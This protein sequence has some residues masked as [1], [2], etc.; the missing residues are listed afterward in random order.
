MLSSCLA[1]GTGRR[2]KPGV[3][4]PAVLALAGACLASCQAIDGFNRDPEVIFATGF[5]NSAIEPR[6]S[7][8][9]VLVDLTPPAPPA[10]SWDALETGPYINGAWINYEA[11]DDSQRKA[12]L[13]DDPVDSS[14]TVLKFILN[15]AAIPEAGRMKGRVNMIF[16][17]MAE[18]AHYSQRVRLY[19]SPDMAHLKDWSQKIDWLTLFEF[20]STDNQRITLGLA[21][22]AG[23]GP[24]ELFFNL[25]YSSKPLGISWKDDYSVTA[26]Q[27]AVP[28]GE[29]LDIEVQVAAGSGEAATSTV[30]LHGAGTRTTLFESH[31]GFGQYWGLTRVNPMK[32]YT[33]E[34]LIDYMKD[35]GWELSV[36]WDDLEARRNIPIQ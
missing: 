26:T 29:W 33:S 36:Y 8:S 28:F 32:L 27:F 20:W 12:L 24:Q 16:D 11:G 14:N 4:L 2:P 21:K 31:A 1:C 23:P 6:N 19:L 34:A 25:E 13:C 15:E 7:V 22:N 30:L 9:D 35:N 5:S 10:Y 17:K 18:Y 3:W